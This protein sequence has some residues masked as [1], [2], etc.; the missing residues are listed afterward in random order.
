MTAEP[1]DRWA[2][3]ARIVEVRSPWLSVIGER[4]VDGAGQQ[5]EYWRVEKPDSLIVITVHRGRLLLPVPSYRP[6]VGRVTLDFAGGRLQD[7]SLVPATAEVIVRREFNL[8][9]ADLVAAEVPI[10]PVGWDVDSS[11]SSQRVYGLALELRDEVVV[12]DESIGASFPATRL[13][14]RQA[15]RELACVQCRAVLHE[16]LEREY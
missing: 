1:D 12:S 15:L 5:L 3:L 11:T 4:L 14:G 7:P 2:V 16:W 9:G 6:G 13:G 10:N 8:S